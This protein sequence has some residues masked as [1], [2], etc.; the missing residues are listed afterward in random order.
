LWQIAWLIVAAAYAVPVVYTANDRLND[1]AL[2]ARERLIL[3]YQLWELHPEYRGTPKNWTR[4]AARLLTDNQLLRRVRTKYGEL[5]TEIELDY[6]RDLSIAQ[7]E[8]VMVAAAAWAVPVAA[9]YGLG[10][11]VLR[12]RR[13]PVPSQQQP[14]TPA[15]S[16]S[17]YR[18]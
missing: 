1:V 9:L 2:R 13:P 4:F 8:V 6:R 5:A 18:R 14:E 17:R 3:Q 16:D 11:F 7:G 12:R 15:V 10:L